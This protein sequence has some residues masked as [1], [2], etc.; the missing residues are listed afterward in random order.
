[1][2]K[3]IDIAMKLFWKEGYTQITM[4]DICKAIGIKPPSFYHA[5]GSKE[6]LFLKTLSYYGERYWNDV[7]D[8]FMAEADIYKAVEYFFEAAVGIYMQHD[9][10]KGCFIDI[11]TIGLSTSEQRIN[12]ALEENQRQTKNMLR[13]R[14]L[15]AL[16]AGQLPHDCNVPAITGALYTFLKGI[17][18]MAR[19]H[20][21]QAELKEISKLGLS[22]LPPKTDM[23]I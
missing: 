22:L 11:S 23:P 8:N 5:F 14:L 12:E 17:A 18:A 13:K 19:E 7:V 4:M 6:D 20:I 15:I 1:M 10:P 16:D 21:C 9:L 2:A 3:A